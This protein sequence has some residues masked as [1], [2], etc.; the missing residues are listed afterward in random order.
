[1]TVHQTAAHSR[2]GR[3][4]ALESACLH[5][6][7][8]FRCLVPLGRSVAVGPPLLTLPGNQRSCTIVDGIRSVRSLAR[9]VAGFTLLIA[10]SLMLALPG[11]GWV[12]I[13]LG[14][15][16]LAPD[17]A[18]ARRALDRLK[19]VGAKG[20]EVSRGWLQRWRRKSGTGND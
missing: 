10:G 11:P 2:F 20:A 3:L 1:M 7:I 15:A 4:A 14:L 5:G 9:N 6:A 17:F 12:T 19:D 18:W 8:S 13:A 16:L